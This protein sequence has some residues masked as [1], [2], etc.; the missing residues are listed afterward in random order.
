MASVPQDMFVAILNREDVF[1]TEE[2]QWYLGGYVFF[3]G[4][5]HSFYIDRKDQFDNL[6]WS[7]SIDEALE[8]KPL[9][10]GVR[11]WIRRIKKREEGKKSS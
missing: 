9:R 4:K 3:D 1:F 5:I 6:H 8:T 10:R 7:R 11:P 2:N